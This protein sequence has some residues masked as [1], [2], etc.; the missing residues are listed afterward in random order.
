MVRRLSILNSA[1]NERRAASRLS[2][3]LFRI[4]LGFG[5]VIST[6]YMTGHAQPELPPPPETVIEDAPG[7]LAADIQTIDGFIV[8]QEPLQRMAADLIGSEVIGAEGESIGQI[9]DLLVDRRDRIIGII[10]GV[11]G[12]LG[13]GE[14]EVGIPIESV[15]IQPAPDRDDMHRIHAALTRIEIEN[16]REF[17]RTARGWAGWVPGMPQERILLEGVPTPRSPPPQLPEPPPLPP[18][19]GAPGTR[20]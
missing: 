20:Q 1:R 16:A 7:T 19:P 10:V 4:G 17:N 14:R 8:T 18:E 15:L 3:G 13:I 11:G 2:A 12:F 6:G 5:I 9:T